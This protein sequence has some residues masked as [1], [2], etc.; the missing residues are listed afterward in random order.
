MEPY[1]DCYL[2]SVNTSDNINSPPNHFTGIHRD[3]DSSARTN[4]TTAPAYSSNFDR[5]QTNFENGMASTKPYCNNSSSNE[6]EAAEKYEMETVYGKQRFRIARV[7]SVKARQFSTDSY[8]GRDR[9]AEKSVH[10][11][12]NFDTCVRHNPPTTIPVMSPNERSEPTPFHKTNEAEGQFSGVPCQS[13]PH[14]TS[15]D[16]NAAQAEVA[17]RK[18][19]RAPLSRTQSLN[20]PSPTLGR[21]CRQSGRYD[22]RGDMDTESITG[23]ANGHPILTAKESYSTFG[24]NTIEA[25]PRLDHFFLEPFP[26][27]YENRS[28]RPTLAELHDIMEE[29]K[30]DEQKNKVAA[31]LL[32]DEERGGKEV[33]TASSS[34]PQAAT[35]F[36][37]IKGVLVR[38]L[39]NIWGVM[40]FLRLSWVVG[41]A[42]IGLS[43]VVILLAA[44]VTT[45]T[46]LSM[47]AI[48]TNGEVK[49]G[50]AYYLISRSLGPE[51]GGA[52]GIVFS[53]ANAV[54]IAMYVVG[55]AETVR[56]LLKAN[57]ALL[58]DEVNDI[59]IIGVITITL[60]LG[61]AIIGMEWE[62]RAQLIL[63]GI[64][65]ISMSAY[66]IGTFI[67][68]N[69]D[70]F[71]KGYTGYRVDV[72]KENFLPDF[73]NEEFFSV[74]SIFF[75]AATGI[76]AG[77]NISGDLKDAQVSIPKGTLLAIAISSVVYILC[78]W[79]LGA[80]IVRDASGAIFYAAVNA[81][82]DGD[83]TLYNSTAEDGIKKVPFV[84]M[85]LMRNCTLGEDGAC[86]YGLQ[87][88]F[89]VMERIALFGPLVTAGIFSATL[90]SALASLVSAPKVFQAVCKDRIFPGIHVLAKGAGK[91]DNPRRLYFL[92][93]FIGIAFICIGELNAIAPIISNFFLMSYA[94]INYSCFDAS[95]AN[96]P[97]WRP[98]F[99][100]YSMWVSL[101]GAILCIAVMFI[102][103]WWTAL[104]TFAV[105]ASLYIYVHHRKPDVNWGS[106]TQA[107]VYKSALQSTLKLIAV[108]DHIKNFRP[109]VLL[110][111]GLPS[112]RPALVDF[113]SSFTRNSS[114]M[115]CCNVI[116]DPNVDSL[117]VQRTKEEYSWLQ[118][119]KIKCFYA[120]IVAP[121]FRLGVQAFM[122]TCG[123]GK[124]RPNTMVIG[125]KNRWR[126]GEPK[127][128]EDYFNT[129]HDGFDMQ[130]GVGILRVKEGFQCDPNFVDPP[131]K[132][133]EEEPPEEEPAPQR[134]DDD[135][136]EEPKTP[137]R[138][139]SI[140]DSTLLQ[141]MDDIIATPDVIHESIVKPDNFSEETLKM[142]NRFN[143]KQK[144]GTI[145]VW[146]LFDDG[147]LTLL[148]PY[149]I[150]LESN[151]NKNK[152][153]VFTAG[154]K[155]GELDREQRQLATLLSKFRIECK[156]MTVIPDVGKIPRREKRQEFDSLLEGF[157]L[158]EEKGETKEKYPWKTTRD[159]LKL[160]KDKTNRHIRL[161]ELLLQHSSE[162]SLIVMTLPMPRKGTCSSGLYMAWID[163]LTR[164]LP[165]ILL[166]RGNQKSVLT[167][168][169]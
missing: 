41:Q 110:L 167:F 12:D 10:S 161:R 24:Q 148:I 99:Q 95:L 112:S 105:I 162:A 28:R 159:Q 155:K 127:E 16:D 85:S 81:T 62:A 30:D 131:R 103:K 137:E 82:I 84:T 158:D 97:G 58:I 39:L 21:Q 169:S 109:Q 135:D 165:P 19:A 33:T 142:M 130:F 14:R 3:R 1:R 156:D 64:L 122:Q 57:N 61:I 125:F 69:N 164:D 119:R 65:L 52:I 34:A 138:R 2:R 160:L 26:E 53:I 89:Q 54:A 56:D 68:P 36:G 108:E 29:N 7:D 147:G 166:L 44:V 141:G 45:I 123:I 22:S 4:D 72:F 13:P 143:E 145:D 153:R 20:S 42:G 111:S 146:W 9:Y 60:L 132:E 115:M 144:K 37:W 134:Y 49:G 116:V 6:H 47:S 149:L 106:S 27:G 35:K 140:F 55:F 92:A 71:S 139:P 102:I 88:D 5:N 8:D 31:P 114:L 121:D 133:I 136:I 98:A 18:S 100:F 117:K 17:H 93:Y 75:P 107:H 23:V 78:A 91:G 152:L 40:L 90:S 66:I 129:I 83:M 74:F 32:P 48:C 73:R 76:L 15:H 46:T 70:N 43:T 87:H 120:P 67:A 96:S 38:C 168:Y 94:L 101:L 51:F 126:Q 151:W 77:A 50:G 63:L 80:C 124:L 11:P 86:K 163:T 25:L 154:T 104:L 113:A 128:V 79:S 118:R 59:R 150:S 157:I